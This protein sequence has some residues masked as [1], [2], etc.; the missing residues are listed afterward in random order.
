MR[1]EQPGGRYV[2]QLIGA[3]NINGSPMFH[4]MSGNLGYQGE[5]HLYPDMPSSRYGEIAPRVREI[6]QRHCVECHGARPG[7]AM[8]GLHI[9]D[10][11]GL[12]DSARRIVV[13]GEPD[14]SR[15]IQRIKDGS[16]PPEEEEVR[17][18]RVSE[19]EL[20]ILK[21]WI[22][23]GAPAFGSGDPRATGPSAVPH[24]ELAARTRALFLKRCYDCHNYIEASGGITLQ[25]VREIA[26][27]GVDFIS[28][29]ALT[30]SAPALDLS[31]IL[32]PLP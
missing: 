30:H 9:L 7:K 13:P 4:I 12:L 26:S 14:D 3:A 16:M 15:L 28:V 1:D 32:E 6:L 21:A 24:S 18:P 25:G 23:G 2:R 17:L 20:V 31:L 11:K 29:G 22:R 5:H 8:K 27:T 10:H 19:E